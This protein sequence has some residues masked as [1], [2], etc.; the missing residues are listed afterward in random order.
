MKH[1]YHRIAIALLGL[2]VALGFTGSA[3]AA[4][5]DGSFEVGPYLNWT[6]WD[7]NSGVD[8]D[9]GY[10]LWL[11]WHIKNGHEIEF[12]YE[13]ASPDF[14]TGDGV[15]VSMWMFGYIYN[16]KNMEKLMPFIRAGVGST[17]VQIDAFGV[18]EDD[19][20]YRVGGG[21]RW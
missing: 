7:S 9:Y 18:D 20:T 11:G 4:L 1:V 2:A 19:T 15:D 21:A 3:S 14:D 6:M 8:D 12:N 10:G 13:L 16:F 17:N 5:K